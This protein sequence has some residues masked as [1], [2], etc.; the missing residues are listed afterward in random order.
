MRSRLDEDE[1]SREQIQTMMD[2]CERLTHLMTSTLAFSK[3][4]ELKLG[5][6]NLSELLQSI[7]DRLEHRI[8]SAHIKIKTK[9]SRQIPEINGD[10]NGLEQVF[11]N[12]INNA[13]QAMKEKG[14]GVLSVSLIEESEIDKHYSVRVEISDTGPGI[15]KEAQK[16]IFQPFYSSH[17]NG[18]GLGLTITQRIV[19]AHS[20]Q[21][22]VQSFEGGTTFAVRLPRTQSTP[23]RGEP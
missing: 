6:I 14:G 16:Q 17:E 10:A 9:L 13:I 18:T 5:A 2:D 22:G 4:T 23:R 11:T 3:T 7:L 8:A 20:G 15:S 19:N 21:I 12:I 1:K